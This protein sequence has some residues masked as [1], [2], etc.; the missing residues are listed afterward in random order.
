MRPFFKNN[1]AVLLYFSKAEF[2]EVVERLTASTSEHP[3][4]LTE[5]VQDFLF[6]L[7]AGQPG[8]ASAVLDVLLNAEVTFTCA[9]CSRRCIDHEYLRVSWFPER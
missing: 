7:T 3:F 8:C 2:A 9:L 4:V 1:A 6:E 5:G